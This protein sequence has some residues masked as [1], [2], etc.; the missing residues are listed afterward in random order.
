MSRLLVALAFLFAGSAAIGAEDYSALFKEAIDN[1]DWDFQDEWAYTES[2]LMEGELWLGRYDPRLDE[3]D[4]WQ[5]ISVDGREPTDKEA[6]KYLH[7]K[8]EHDTASDSR[9]TRIVGADSLELLEDADDYWLFT[10]VPDDEEEAFI[11]SVDA[12]V[13]IMKDG[14]YVHSIDIRNH[15][16]IKPGFGTKLTS[17]LMRLEF[18]HAA[19]DGP[20]VPKSITTHVTGRA[21]FVIAIDD[22][23]ATKNTDFKHVVE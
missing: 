21:L 7:D 23:E 20:I 18:G 10:F 12:K 11:D 19:E 14:R 2:S 16:D 17:L 8:D 13:K 22:T 5:L 15:S 4:R 1:I 6:R 9:T 3:D